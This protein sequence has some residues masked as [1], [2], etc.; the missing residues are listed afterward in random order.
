MCIITCS[1]FILTEGYRIFTFVHRTG[2][3]FC[4]TTS[5]ITGTVWYNPFH[6]F[7]KFRPQSDLIFCK[8]DCNGEAAPEPR[9]QMVSNYLLTKM[10]DVSF[11]SFILCQHWPLASSALPFPFLGVFT[12][13][14][15]PV[16]GIHF[17]KWSEIDSL[18][19]STPQLSLQLGLHLS[20]CFPELHFSLHVSTMLASQLFSDQS[21][22][23]R[24]ACRK[25]FGHLRLWLPLPAAD[26]FFLCD[27]SSHLCSEVASYFLS[28]AIFTG[29]PLT[30][31][32][33]SFTKALCQISRSDV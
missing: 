16:L 28:S 14:N 18:F 24:L 33:S 30:L 19:S 11:G 5:P 23:C 15:P 26:Y 21:V 12:Q 22:S 29:S 20:C 17:A 7:I 3:N 2:R 8:H 6:K 10:S 1:I 4:A 31:A 9:C 27:I 13:R 32:P 25:G